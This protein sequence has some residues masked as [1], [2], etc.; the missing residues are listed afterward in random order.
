MTLP[1]SLSARA[2]TGALLALIVGGGPFGSAASADQIQARARFDRGVRW[3]E[4]GEHLRAVVEFN[5][6]IEHFPHYPDAFTARG[7]AWANLGDCT[8]AIAD[9]DEAV[10]LQPTHAAAYAS[11][12][13]CRGRLG[14][15]EQAIADMRIADELRPDDARI[16][17]QLGDLLFRNG[18]G[19]AARAA[20]ERS[21]E[22]D[23]SLAPA[24]IQ[25]AVVCNDLGDGAG[26][27]G[28]L[29]A[30]IALDADDFRSW[31]HRA[32]TKR[33]MGDA[34]GALEDLGE[35]IRLAPE[36]P[37]LLSLRGMLRY[38]LQLNAD[39][40][41]DLRRRCDL[42]PASQGEARLYIWLA[43]AA[44][45]DRDEASSDLRAFAEARAAEARDDRD[46]DDWFPL[47]CGFL[48]GH[49]D[50]DNLLAAAATADEA[51]TRGRLCEAHFYIG[52]VH[53]IEARPAEAAESFRRC[54]DTAMRDLPEFASARAGLERLGPLTD[55]DVATGVER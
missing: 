1:H 50:A 12:A 24:Y 33:S 49:M 14:D 40:V 10:R 31:Q 39:A 30:A 16:V 18:D 19:A 38:D 36:H 17:S 32:I 43:M 6:A 35:A 41:S 27:L 2:I 46:A 52:S 42:D 20:L 45:G 54:I 3:N 4:A 5:R 23:P 7:M 8:K 29:S 34:A 51:A 25:L 55:T 47:L 53:M 44:S 26:A 28:H 11:R 13:W 22:L 37:G 48:L 15:L 21:I 9:Y